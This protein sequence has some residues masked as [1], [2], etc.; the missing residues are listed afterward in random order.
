MLQI[1]TL[2]DLLKAAAKALDERDVDTLERLMQINRGWLQ[3]ESEKDA[4]EALLI[5]MENA[6]IDLEC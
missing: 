1:H 2:S 5:A 6:C 3:H 4:Q